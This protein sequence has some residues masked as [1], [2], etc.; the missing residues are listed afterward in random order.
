MCCV[1]YDQRSDVSLLKLLCI[2]AMLIHN[3]TQFFNIFYSILIST[4]FY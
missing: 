3:A 2:V 1:D 4:V